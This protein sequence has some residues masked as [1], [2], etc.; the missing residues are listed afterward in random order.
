MW[1]NPTE[2][3]RTTE[4]QREQGSYDNFSGVLGGSTLPNLIQKALTDVKL[5]LVSCILL[6]F[7]QVWKS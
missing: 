2:P 7:E 1:F 6:W 5:G 4:L 3:L